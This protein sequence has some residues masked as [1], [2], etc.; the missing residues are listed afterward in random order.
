MIENIYSIM[1]EKNKIKIKMY[2][3]MYNFWF[4]IHDKLFLWKLKN[5]KYVKLN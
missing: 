5:E 1:L 3:Y 4:V 2:S